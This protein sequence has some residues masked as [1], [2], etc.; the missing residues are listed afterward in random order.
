MTDFYPIV[1]DILW[2]QTLF[3]ESHLKIFRPTERNA[4]SV[5]LSGCLFL[6]LCSAMH[7]RH[8]PYAN[9]MGLSLYRKQYYDIMIF[10]NF[11]L[12]LEFFLFQLCFLSSIYCT[13]NCSLTVTVIKIVMI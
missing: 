13:C 12:Y 3:R 7:C 5:S 1:Q 11:L 4:I 6:N 2:I 8:T 10:I 9:Q